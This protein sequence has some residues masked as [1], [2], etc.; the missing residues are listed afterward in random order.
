MISAILIILA[1]IANSIGD[2]IQFHWSTSVFAGRGWDSWAN[3]QISWSRKW[4][5]GNAN[6]M[7]EEAFPGSSTVFVS[8][9]DL[10]H[11]VK[12]IQLTTLFLACVLWS[13]I[14]NLESWFLETLTNFALL[15]FFYGATFELF[16]SRILSKK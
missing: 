15:R 13:P 14:I 3:P 6:H 9:T 12:S 10:W 8:F 2:K 1:A 4:K 5:N 11:F 7:R 16:F